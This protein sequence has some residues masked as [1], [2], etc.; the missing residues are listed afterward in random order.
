MAASPN[1][2]L[3]VSSTSALKVCSS[4]LY[5]ETEST[6]NK[7]SAARSFTHWA[8]LL[9]IYMHALPN[10]GCFATFSWHLPLSTCGFSGFC[11]HWHQCNWF[12]WPL[13]Q[14]HCSK[15]ATNCGHNCRRIYHPPNRFFYSTTIGSEMP[16]K[17]VLLLQFTYECVQQARISLQRQV[18]KRE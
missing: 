1:S 12:H 18:S 4:Q 13:P 9:L 3:S 2:C 11:W 6:F 14:N 17:M 10:P 8:S 15:A 16:L 7:F 5:I